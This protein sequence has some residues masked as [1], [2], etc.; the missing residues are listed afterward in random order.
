M[1]NALEILFE[2]A[3]KVRL[4]RLFMHNPERQ[5]SV[6]EIQKR[7]QIAGVSVLKEIKKLLKAGVIKDR[8]GYL[9]SGEENSGSAS[10]PRPSKGKKALILAANPDFALKGELRDLVLKSLVAPRKQLLGQIRRL[11]RIRLAVIS[12]IFIG[13][14]FTRTDLLIV[15]DGI[16]E[17]SLAAF[18]ARTESE[19]GKSLRYTIMDMDEFKYRRDMYDRFL[20]DILEF[21]HEKLINKLNI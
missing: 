5:F 13:N 18:L 19:M 14:D 21:P 4:L 3:A 16:K 8:I 20:R 12:G 1:N 9:P 17:R 6:P 7:C 2:S 11:G 10:G 15:G